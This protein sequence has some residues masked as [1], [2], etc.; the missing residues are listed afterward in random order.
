[1]GVRRFEDLIAWQRA[2]D[3]QEEVFAITAK[4]PASRDFKFCN[5][6]RDSARS[7]A[8]NT[9]EGF[10]IHD[11]RDRGYLTIEK[12]EQLTRLSLRAI[13]ANTRLIAYLSHCNPPEPYEGT[14]EP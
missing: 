2:H 11:A 8:R 3:L 4:P 9:A 14:E 5:Q 12:W 6:I 1:M 13:K 10:G 7:A